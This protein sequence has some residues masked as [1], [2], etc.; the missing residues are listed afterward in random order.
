MYIPNVENRGGHYGLGCRQEVHMRAWLVLVTPA[1][2]AALVAC[3]STLAHQG[4]LDHAV[5][6]GSF[7]DIMVEVPAVLQRYGYAIYQ[8]RPTSSTLYLETGW[9]E[10]APFDDEAEEGVEYARTRFIARGRKAGPTMYTLTISAENQVM[11]PPD[12][13]P[14]T[15]GRP[16]TEW[17]VM[18][19]TDMYRSYVREITTEIEMKVD[20]GL[21]KYDAPLDRVLL[22]NATHP[23]S[24]P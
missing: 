9:Q 23:R 18:A 1:T 10:R 13:T 24:R 3:A 8:N 5:G 17:S 6:R 21:R 14:E 4:T 2:A 7:R 20:A 16:A 15:A 19:P 11:T 22:G 12:T